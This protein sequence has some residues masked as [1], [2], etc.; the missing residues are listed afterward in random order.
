MSEG[1][2]NEVTMK[3]NPVTLAGPRLKAGEKAPAF[4][5]VGAGLSVITLAET[6][7]K[8][9][10][11]SVVPSLDTPVCNIQT[12]RFAQELNSLG[13]KIAAYT[14][15]TDLPFAMARF[16]GEAKITNMA[17]LSDCHD[18]SFGQN[19]GVLITD[20]PVP[21]LARAIFIVDA[22]DKITYFELV[23][24]IA[25]EPNYDAALTALKAAA[26]A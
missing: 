9:R 14:V 11:F 20:L 25:T 19:Y 8:A 10:L 21:L 6:T 17:N 13:D 7:G 24:E 16:C 5:C 22:S 18:H 2:K 15:S 23:P 3:G 4:T 1:R 12:K 26:G